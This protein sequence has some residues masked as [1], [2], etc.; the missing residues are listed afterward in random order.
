MA[1]L[2][3]SLA[4]CDK[5]ESFTTDSN[6]KLEFSLDTLHF[7]TV[8]TELGSA[9]RTIKVYNRNDKPLRISKV[10]IEGN[11]GAF[12]RMNVDGRSGN[13]V[14]D[15]E[16]WAKDSIYVFVEVTINPDQPE[17]ISPFVIE[18]KVIFETNGNTQEVRLEAWGQNANYLPGR[19]NKGVPVV[20]TCN[21]EEWVW[22]D[23]KPY[24]I[25]GEVLIDSCLL[26]ITEG[27]HVYVHGGVAQ[28]DLFGIFNDGILYFLQNGRLKVEGTL[29]NPVIF[30]GDRLEEPFQDV[31]GQW[32]GI[33]LNKGSKGN[34]IEHAII[35]NAAFGIYV[36][37]TAELNIRNSQ[38]YNTTG[39]G[40]IGFHGTIDASNCLI[41]NNNSTS[42]QLILGG[43]Y[44]FTQCTFASYGVDASAVS[45]GNS[46]CYKG[47]PVSC[48]IGEVLPLKARFQNCIFFGSRRDE[49]DFGDATGRQDPSFFD[50]QFDHCLVKVDELLTREMGLYADFF[51]SYCNNC[52]NGSRTDELFIDP[53]EDDYHLDTMSIAIDIG[54]PLPAFP[55][56]LE[57]KTRDENPDVGC[58][59][60]P[61]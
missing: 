36:D 22:D 29:E 28:N 47:S 43:N 21:D 19:F 49:I 50:V 54:L 33:I 57:G 52:V 42:L 46:F 26:R 58:F 27:T 23:A 11:D 61:K 13:M 4:S 41:Y 1:M 8:F 51:E 10:R 2:I 34:D 25:Y 20:Y 48:E 17:S 40:I 9:T 56:D 12:F 14:E 32:Y 18:D 59:E 31:A 44:N 30:E 37:S 3:W 38:F 45:L 5:Q 15:I 24:V 55:T 53:D 35:K 6:A 16:V 60:F 7:D 39:G